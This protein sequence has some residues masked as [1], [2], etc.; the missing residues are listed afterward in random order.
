METQ[1]AFPPRGVAFRWAK[2]RDQCPV[3][4]PGVQVL[5]PVYG[6]AEA[7][8]GAVDRTEDNA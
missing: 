4:L 2:K 1:V 8:L 5:A 6:A 7:G 3:L